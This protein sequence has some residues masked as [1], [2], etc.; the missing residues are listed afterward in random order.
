MFSVV[1]DAQSA[2]LSQ[3]HVARR[4]KRL[5][6]DQAEL[7]L[8]RVVALDACQACRRHGVAKK[9]PS[10]LCGGKGQHC[11][12]CNAQRHMHTPRQCGDMCESMQPRGQ[13]C[14]CIVSTP[15][16]DRGA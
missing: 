12:S 11:I 8:P 13:P 6:V 1:Q 3:R 14:D 2:E 7:K 10:S 15:C 5:K 9:E 4:A 16:S